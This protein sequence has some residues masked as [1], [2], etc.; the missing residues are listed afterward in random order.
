MDSSNKRA[1][2]YCY[3]SNKTEQNYQLDIDLIREKTLSKNMK[4]R[5]GNT[6][7]EYV[8]FFA[9]ALF[10]KK[11]VYCLYWTSHGEMDSWPN[12]LYRLAGAMVNRII[13]ALNSSPTTQSYKALSSW[14][15][16]ATESYQNRTN[17]DQRQ[18]TG[19]H[20]C[21]RLP[22]KR[23]AWVMYMRDYNVL[24]E[25]NAPG[26]LQYLQLRHW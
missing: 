12:R 3:R 11:L 7:E 20:Y 26:Y 15:F 21:L 14:P 25:K 6:L 5:I 18:H 23:K 16:F 19:G 24:N 10:G 4:E 22:D 17:P 2:C 8:K 1:G 13:G 9:L